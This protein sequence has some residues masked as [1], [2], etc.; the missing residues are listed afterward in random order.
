MMTKLRFSLL[1]GFLAGA[2]IPAF[3]GVLGLLLFNVPEGQFRRMYGDAVYLTC[4]FWRIDGEKALILMPLL[5]GSMFAILAAFIHKSLGIP[6]KS[7][8]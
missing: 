6:M 2:I 3:W 7:K 5:N 8:R 1:I 4:P